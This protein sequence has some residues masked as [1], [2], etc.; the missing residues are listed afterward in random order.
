MPNLEPGGPGAKEYNL[1]VDCVDRHAASPAGKNKVA[2][3][4]ENATG[5]TEKYTFGELA[6]LTNRLA[7]SLQGLGLKPGDR[8]LLR[9]GNVPEFQQSFI[10][11]VKAG[12]IPIPTSPAL[13][14]DELAFRLRDSEAAAIIAGAEF[15]PDDGVLADLPSLRIRIGVGE[16]LPHSFLPFGDL[17]SRGSPYFAV[18]PTKPLDPAFIIYTSGTTGEPK[19]AVHAHRWPAAND[20]SGLYWQ[21]YQ[22]D[23]IVAC[24]GPLSWI[25]P[26]GNAFLFA[27]RFGASVF[28]YDG[29]F[30]PQRWLRLLEKYQITNLASVPANYRQLL[31]AWRDRPAAYDLRHLR[32]AVSCG[33]PLPADLP[34]AF[35]R[36]FGLPVLDGL[37]MT[38]CM[39]YVS[40]QI[41]H[42]IQ[43]GS[44]GLTQPGHRLAILDPATLEPLEN[45][46]PG[47]LA[48][49]RQDPGLFLEYWRRPRET[50][51]A[52]AGE[53]FLTGDVIRRDAEGYH[54]A[55]GRA[56]DLIPCGGTLV[57]P[58]EVESVLLEHP[59]IAEAAVVRGLDSQG[60]CLVKAF[61]V[62][63]GGD[64]EVVAQEL[65][66]LAYERLSDPKVPSEIEF[67]GFLPRTHS[68]KIKRKM[69]RE[70]EQ[71]RQGRRGSL[72]YPELLSNLVDTGSE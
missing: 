20:P 18:A 56:D 38:E 30:E 33:E 46:E 2:L 21:A 13:R 40:N 31:E 7:N 4:W 34:T 22:L 32:H 45:G 47:L 44:C 68:G 42:P 8:V 14:A 62:S 9:L 15:L 43:A 63:R 67:V 25:Y 29:P 59:A 58:F 17:L 64:D 53:W 28:L 39:T 61:V 55:V 66:D 49:H 11:A 57:S 3:Y 41:G 54:W 37:G 1:A 36:E 35:D 26:L 16:D 5:Q 19:G 24:T 70:I 60:R 10:G 23:D 69:L 71:H 27:W 51:A 52:L 50:A 72:T 48:I 65:L 6:A 12:L